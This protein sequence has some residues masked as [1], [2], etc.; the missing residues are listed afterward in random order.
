MM[1]L[2][3]EVAD[4]GSLE[5]FGVLRDVFTRIR[6]WFIKKLGFDCGSFI[7][8]ARGFIFIDMSMDGY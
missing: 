1:L 7:S 5:D 4:P 3:E 8:L 2:G 6:G